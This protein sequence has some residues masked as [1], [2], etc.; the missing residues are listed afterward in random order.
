MSIRF[1]RFNKKCLNCGAT[2]KETFKSP[3]GD[4][5]ECPCCGSKKLK[6]VQE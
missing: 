6:D 1:L 2:I 4:I 5:T 3:L